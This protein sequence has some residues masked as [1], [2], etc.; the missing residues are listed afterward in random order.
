MKARS[1]V[2][3]VSGMVSIMLSFGLIVAAVEVGSVNAAST[4]PAVVGQW[5]A[6]TTMPFVGIHSM[7]M[8][9]GSVL[10]FDRSL[11]NRGSPGVLFNPA[12]GAMVDVRIPYPRDIFCAGHNIL[13][14]GSVFVSGGHPPVSGH[15]GIGVKLTDVFNPIAKTWTPGPTLD[16]ARWYPSN[17]S[18]GDGT[19]LIFSG[20]EVQGDPVLTVDRYDPATGQLTTLPATANRKLT[21][22]PKLH[23]MAN[24]KLFLAGAS[25]AGAWFD[26][27]T[28]TWSAAP[29][30]V[31]G[32]QSFA[33]VV[34]PDQRVMA[35][36]GTG[37]KSSAEIVD[38][39][40]PNPAWKLTAPMHFGRTHP[41]AVL[42]PDGKVFVVGGGTSVSSTARC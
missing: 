16:Q 19:T 26:P 6:P 37:P 41:N 1:R 14:D 13:P 29:R 25:R 34:L 39:S 33:S 22:Y 18:L 38:L 11:G 3:R 35:I 15:P 7:V 32:R 10:L 40:A 12:T 17:V 5:T 28:A 31:Q 27:D 20:N 42:L 24:G 23:L 21:L 30:M 8:R 2:T 9:N 36:G 4:D